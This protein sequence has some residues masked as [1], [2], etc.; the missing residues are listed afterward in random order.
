MRKTPTGLGL[1]NYYSGL[2]IWQQ[3]QIPYMNLASQLSSPGYKYQR[4]S[5]RNSSIGDQIDIGKYFTVLAGINYAQIH[6]TSFSGPD[7]VR[8]DYDVGKFSPTA[9]LLFKPANWITTYF[10]Y[11][12]SLQEGLV[13][14]DPLATNNGAV[15][16]PY[17]MKQYEVGAK[18]TVNNTLYTLAFFD[19]QQSLLYTIN[20]QDGTDAYMES[21]LGV[22]KGIEFSATGEIAKGV[23]VLGGFM[24]A[25]S[26]IKNDQANPQFNGK[27]PQG[28]VRSLAKIT[29]E[30]DLPFV[31][32]LTLT[33]GAYYT[34][35]SYFDQA[36][37]AR[38]PSHT[39]FDVGARYN[40]KLYGH[41]WTFRAYLQRGFRTVR[42]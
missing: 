14:N 31:P 4:T 17:P 26:E 37:T 38:I 40:A 24:L 8:G 22:S 18:A 27:V 19:I 11:G 33:G 3:P 32:G 35:D 9:A 1:T 5:Y 25:D 15:L 6:D 12:E 23:R 13:V 16:P 36:N 21:G 42:P 2:S 30:Y 20:N 7:A 39:T 28:A 10:S 34:G 41:D 29:A